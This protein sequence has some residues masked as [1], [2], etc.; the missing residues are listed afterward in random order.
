MQLMRYF[1]SGLVSAQ[2]M[3]LEIEK[4]LLQLHNDINSGVP[5]LRVCRNNSSK[6][7]NFEKSIS[8][9]SNKCSEIKE[10]WYKNN[11]AAVKI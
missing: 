11:T 9:K 5:A 8:Y 10:E 2:W 4:N 7:E 6:V 3:S 1:S